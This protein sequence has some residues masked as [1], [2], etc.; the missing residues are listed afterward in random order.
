MKKFIV[1]VSLV[2]LV[3]NFTRAQEL[4]TVE[5]KYRGKPIIQMTLNDKKT[6]V[7]LDTGS[8]YTILDSG[9]KQK[10]DFFVSHSND[11]RINVSGLGST[12][13]GLSETSNAELRFGHVK[14]KGP[15]YA[16]DLSTVA[17]SIQLRTGKRITAIIGTHMMRSYGFVIDMRDS[18]ATLHIKSKKKKNQ[19]DFSSDD[20]I[21]AKNAKK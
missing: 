21:I 5:A 11:D 14:L 17:K 3:N 7:L 18:T 10:Y 19:S 2:A 15:T 12:N 13:N 6:W 1:I 8:E 16:F 20:M 9:A 4:E